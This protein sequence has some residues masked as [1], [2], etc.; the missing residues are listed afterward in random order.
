MFDLVTDILLLVL[1]IVSGGHALL[2]KRD[3]RAGLGWVALCLLVPF[4]GPI[5]Y[6]SFGVNRIRTRAKRYQS[7]WTILILRGDRRPDRTH[8]ELIPSDHLPESSL[9]HVRTADSLTGGPLVGGNSVEP[10]YNGEQAYPAMLAAIDGARDRVWLSTYIFDGDDTG[11]RFADGLKAAAERGVDVR[12]LVD[13]FGM[14]HS[15]PPG[16]RLL[17]SHSLRWAEFLP[18]TSVRSRFHFN[19]RNHRKILVADDSVGFTGGMNIGDRHLASRTDH[20]R[21]AHDV[22]FRVVGPVVRAMADTFGVDWAFATREP[23]EPPAHTTEP[24]Y[25]PS[26]CR[27]VLDGPN[28]DFE[29][30]PQLLLGAFNSAR[31]HVRIMTPYFVP[32]REI[33]STIN[34]VSLRDVRVDVVLPA[35]SNHPWVDW[36]TRA[37]LWEFLSRGVNVYYQPA[38][39]V[40]T[41]LLTVDDHYALVGSANLDSRSLRLN[42]EFDLEVFDQKLNARLAG[43]FDDCLDRSQRITLEMMD[44]RSLPA[45]LRDATA[46]LFAPYM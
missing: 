1:A 7:E 44:R 20:P 9:P 45:R 24:H 12:V 35:A 19:L 22:H 46:R 37:M 16:R 15:H 33:V 30:L 23:Y 41:K 13:G 10:L 18:F 26:L 40:H 28:E 4:F 21:L 8:V 29:I 34:A 25:E 14:F 32:S 6:W 11:R 38:P 36:A 27:G 2:F 42:F 43:H 3:P 31:R 39:F 17:N 5:L